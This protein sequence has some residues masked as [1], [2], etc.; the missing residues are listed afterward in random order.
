M[1]RKVLN[2]NR[3]M[4]AIAAALLIIGSASAFADNRGSNPEAK[5]SQTQGINRRQRDQRERIRN[6]V[7]SGSLT[8]EEA[9]ELRDDQRA[10]RSQKKGAKHDGAVTK[11]ERQSIRQ[12]QTEAGKRI[13]QLKQ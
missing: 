2:L 5:G 6:G 7:E 3:A 10:I 1:F 11:E 12:S 8:R 9:R 4:S 13:K